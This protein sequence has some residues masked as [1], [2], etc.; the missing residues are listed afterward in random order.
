MAVVTKDA[1][2]SQLFRGDDR[3]R[4]CLKSPSDHILLGA[5]GDHVGKIQQALIAL[6]AGVISADEIAAQFYGPSTARAVKK[7]KGPPR[8]I[9]NRTYQQ[10]PDDIVGQMTID[11][12]D[13]EIFESEKKPPS[14]LVS[15]KEEGAPHDHVGFCTP[16][17]LEAGEHKGTPINPQG[18][19]RK[20]NIFGDH[21]TDYLKFEDFSTDI[22]FTKRS[23]GP[24]RPITFDPPERGGLPDNCASDICMRSSPV[25]DESF[26]R[27]TGKPNTFEEIKRIAMPG[28]RFTYGADNENLRLFQKTVL[29]L[30]P[31]IERVEFK[32]RDGG[33]FTGIVLVIL[34]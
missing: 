12:L 17:R 4:K 11:R 28:C 18:F 9:I 26:T 31:V 23:S 8:N 20:I 24:L 7:Y 15:V 19:G 27:Q 16:L 21:E 34:G 32:D 30:G 14:L 3:L 25:V 29:R 6:G 10:A 5:R 1:L 22:R 13:V 2:V 33:K